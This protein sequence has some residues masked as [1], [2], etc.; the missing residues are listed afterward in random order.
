MAATKLEAG[1]KLLLELFYNGKPAF[2]VPE[3]SEIELRLINQSRQNLENC[4]VKLGGEIIRAGLNLRPDASWSLPYRVDDLVGDLTFKAVG[5]ACESQSSLQ[6]VPQK[7][8]QDEVFYI[9]TERLPGLLSR[10]DAPNGL[11]LRYYDRDEQPRLFDFFSADYTA[12]KLRHFSQSFL[13]QNLA[14][15]ILGRLDY[16]T[17]EQPESE[18]Y[19]IRGPVNWPATMQYWLNRPA[20][21][22]L[23]HQWSRA[24]KNFATLPN[25]LFVRFQ[26]ELE[27]ELLRLVRFVE[28]GGPASSRLQRA[29]PEF[30]ER[31]TR[32]HALT[33]SAL[34]PSAAFALDLDKQ[35]SSLK[36]AFASECSRAAYANPAYT[37]V[38]VLWSEFSSRY[39]ALPE[40]DTQL[41][42]SGLQ[43][44]SKIYELWAACEVA[45]ALGLQFETVEATK[46]FDG[47]PAM[48]AE[49]AIFRSADGKTRLFYNKGLRGGWYSSSRP[50]LPR[51]DLRL[52]SEGRQ[53]FLDVKYRVGSE[54]RAR[55]DDIYKMLAYMH[56]FQVKVGGII[57]PGQQPGLTTLEIKN[58]RDESILEVALRPPLAGEQIEFEQE[59]GERLHKLI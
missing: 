45:A 31:A 15:A 29:L 56:D 13:E 52:E 59:L 53:L 57:F 24:P 27:W 40:D 32:H 8:S 28:L 50:G 22:G 49:S 54:N 37:Q 36:A 41:A 30:R 20:E 39:I 4:A 21:T 47:T 2:S 23:Y 43:P 9:K 33:E 55:P 7:L 34:L 51:P 25:L 11:Q 42:R 46:S 44:M 6:V 38:S 17:P 26:L 14:E 48:A 58:E 3:Y 10:L 12:E 1:E 35:A 19:S 5:P 18:L 16:L